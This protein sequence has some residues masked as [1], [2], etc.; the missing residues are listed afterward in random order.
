MQR[1]PQEGLHKLLC[2]S[3]APHL[4]RAPQCHACSYVPLSLHRHKKGGASELPVPS[5]S[6]ATQQVGA[7]ALLRPAKFIESTGLRMTRQQHHHSQERAKGPD[8]GSS[9]STSSFFEL[10]HPHPLPRTPTKRPPGNHWIPSFQISPLY[11]SL[12]TSQP[13]GVR[14]RPDRAGLNPTPTPSPSGRKTPLKAL[15]F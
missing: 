8:P 6:A 1:A 12:E 5:P 2:F 15:K 3:H 4:R 9:T 13:G 10:E 7:S 14:R 11:S